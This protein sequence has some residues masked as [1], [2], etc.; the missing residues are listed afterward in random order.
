MNIT[1][2]INYEIFANAKISYAIMTNKITFMY[3]CGFPFSTSMYSA[4]IIQDDDKL[5]SR[6]MAATGTYYEKTNTM[7]FY[8]A[9]LHNSHKC[10]DLIIKT[11]FNEILILYYAAAYGNIKIIAQ[12]L[13]Q[14]KFPINQSN[15]DRLYSNAAENGR[16]NVIEYLFNN[17]LKCY[18]DVIS[19]AIK[20]G[21]FD[22][23]KFLHTKNYNFIKP[24]LMNAISKPTNQTD[25]LIYLISHAK[26][27][28]N[29]MLNAAIMYQPKNEKL[30]S[31]LLRESSK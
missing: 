21:Q 6:Y 3:A 25:S 23:A 22:C 14:I 28:T 1:R 2:P 24:T 13:A 10:I 20:H 18:D 11:K 4:A 9:L 30:I 26:L 29:A 12:L 8:F 15:I 5:L 31:Y 16:L 27:N 7:L 17:G 19:I